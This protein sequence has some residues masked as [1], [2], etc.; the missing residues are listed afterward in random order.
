M[1]F[2]FE[3]LVNFYKRKKQLLVG[4]FLA[5]IIAISVVYYYFYQYRPTIIQKAYENLSFAE[6]Y[7][8]IDSLDIALNGRWGNM[9][10]LGI[11][12]KYANTPA[13]NLAYYYAGVIFLH[14]HKFNQALEYLSKFNPSSSSLKSRTHALLGDIHGELGAADEAYLQYRKAIKYADGDDEFIAEY[15]F[16]SGRVIENVSTDK[17]IESYEL[18]KNS[19][20]NTQRAKYIDKYISKL[21]N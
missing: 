16:R 12:N 18:I 11:I 10:L 19:Y 17:A 14:K 4:V 9:G 13:G 5:I 2:S 1:S 21:R 20:A 6:E 3:D 8:R 15:L 7:F